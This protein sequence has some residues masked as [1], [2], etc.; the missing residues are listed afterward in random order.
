MA[1]RKIIFDSSDKGRNY[2]RASLGL[3][4]GSLESRHLSDR[5]AAHGW[6]EIN[7]KLGA[8]DLFG[9]QAATRRASFSLL[10]FLR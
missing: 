3:V 10:K 9:D 5:S 6:A 4:V 1:V 2:R 8:V 7:R